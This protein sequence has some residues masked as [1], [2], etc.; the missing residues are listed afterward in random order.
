[1]KFSLEANILEEEINA[2]IRFSETCEDGEGYDVPKG[3]MKSLAV[4]GLIRRVSGNIYE[5]TL[6]GDNL[7]EN[8]KSENFG[9]PKGWTRMPDGKVKAPKDF[10]AIA[11]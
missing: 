9:L 5:T 11:Q 1:M 6:I 4:I 3:M 10:V 2:L 7:L 8:L